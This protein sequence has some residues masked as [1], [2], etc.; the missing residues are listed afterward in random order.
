MLKPR[1]ERKVEKR[2]NDENPYPDKPYIQ[3]AIN[4]NKTIPVLKT[5]KLETPQRP[6]EL[7]KREEPTKNKSKLYGKMASMDKKIAEK[8][9]GAAMTIK[10]KL[11][12]AVERAQ[13]GRSSKLY[14]KATKA[15]EQGEM[16]R[17]GKLMKKFERGVRRRMD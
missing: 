7:V 11:N 17:A 5:K 1:L 2:R 16:K 6:T 13:A 15:K 10:D 8:M 12:K 9:S 4:R 14:S 3:E